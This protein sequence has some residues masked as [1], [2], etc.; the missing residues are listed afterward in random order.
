MLDDN[1]NLSLIEVNTNPCLET[2]S[3]I[4]LQRLVPQMLDQSLKIAV[5]PFFGAS[6]QQ[7][8]MNQEFVATEIKYS[9]VYEETIKNIRSTPFWDDTYLTQSPYL[10][11]LKQEMS[12]D[13]SNRGSPTKMSEGPSA[14]KSN[15]E[16]EPVG[17]LEAKE[18]A[19]VGAA[20]EP[21]SAA[22]IDGAKEGNE[23]EE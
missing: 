6:E 17:G 12:Q 5:D 2:Q 4:L 23:E 22:Q 18:P 14:L 20:T 16:A 9:M 10:E 21:Q 8:Q 15:A 13:Q 11:K 3:C 7:Y 19:S 1:L